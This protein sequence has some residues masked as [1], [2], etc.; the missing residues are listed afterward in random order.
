MTVF[1]G[2]TDEYTGMTANGDVV[3]RWMMTSKERQEEK[4]DEVRSTERQANK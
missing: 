4:E 3:W 1:H 2:K